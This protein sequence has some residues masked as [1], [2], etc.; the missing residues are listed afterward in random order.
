MRAPTLHR[1]WLTPTLLLMCLALGSG[2]AWATGDD[3]KAGEDVFATHC[4]ECHSLK[5]GKQKKGPSVFGIVGRKA[6]L[7]AGF[8]YSDALKSSGLVWTSPALDAYITLPK[9]AVPGGR[10]KYDGLPDP[11]ARADLIAFLGTLH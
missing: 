2:A 5:S 3:A 7:I 1:R 10:M 6:G 9:K 4:A 11:K 8:D